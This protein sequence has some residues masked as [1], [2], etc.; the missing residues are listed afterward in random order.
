MRRST[1]R[2]EPGVSDSNRLAVVQPSRG[3]AK[4]LVREIFRFVAAH[5]VMNPGRGDVRGLERLAI[6]GAPAD[7]CIGGGNDPAAHRVALDHVVPLGLA[8]FRDG[9]DVDRLAVMVG[10]G[11]AA[12]RVINA[13]AVAGADRGARPRN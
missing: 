6:D 11:A 8:G 2:P 3:P 10:A 4:H 9:V 7:L 13:T 12:L 5:V 1:I